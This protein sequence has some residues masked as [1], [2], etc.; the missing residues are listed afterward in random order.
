MTAHGRDNRV[1]ELQKS[2]WSRQN[3]NTAN[4]PYSSLKAALAAIEL[5]RGPQNE[6]QRRT[7][8]AQ[9]TRKLLRSFDCLRGIAQITFNVIFNKEEEKIEVSGNLIFHPFKRKKNPR[10]KR[11]SKFDRNNVT[12]WRRREAQIASR[13]AHA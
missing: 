3:S 1:T 2:L 10:A 11:P 9:V 4:D 12:R 13:A 8:T 5:K 6:F 7:V